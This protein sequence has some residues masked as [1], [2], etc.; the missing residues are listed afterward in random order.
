MSWELPIKTINELNSHEHWRNRQRRAKS[1]RIAVRLLLRGKL[2]PLPEGVNAAVVLTRLAPS[3]GLD[4]GDGLPAALKHVRDEVA[5]MLGRDDGPRAGIQW[6]Y[7]QQRH[8][9]YAVHV[10]VEVRS[11]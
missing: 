1:Q 3:S 8:P 5:A 11:A 6:L 7:E 4:L 10:A 2:E 9:T